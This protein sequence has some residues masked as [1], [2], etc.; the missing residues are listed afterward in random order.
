MKVRLRDI[1]VNDLD[2]QSVILLSNFIRTARTQEGANISLTDEYVVC[3]VF[4][5][6]LKTN[7][8]MLK[9][10]FNSF[11]RRLRKQIKERR[12]APTQYH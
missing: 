9:V 3:A 7:N 11:Q 2:N 8:P 6:G 1:R 4:N 12:I 5:L 10:V